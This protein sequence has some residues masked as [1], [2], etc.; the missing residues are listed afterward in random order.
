MDFSYEGEQFRVVL[1]MSKKPKKID[2][3]KLV[4]GPLTTEQHRAVVGIKD[5]AEYGIIN[6][7]RERSAPGQWQGNVFVADKPQVD[8]NVV[9]ALANYYHTESRERLWKL[10]VEGKISDAEWNEATA[11]FLYPG[12]LD[13]QAIERAAWAAIK[14]S[15]PEGVAL[16]SYSKRVY[17]SLSE[18]EKKEFAG[19]NPETEKTKQFSADRKRRLERLRRIF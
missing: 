12:K 18:A 13:R 8:F 9:N 6:P 1:K 7:P 19:W 4:K 15:T 5:P 11:R 10:I 3:S 17:E 16:G 14:N 2:R